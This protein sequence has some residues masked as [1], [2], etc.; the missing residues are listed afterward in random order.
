MEE[1]FWIIV[2]IPDDVS[3]GGLFED[4]EFLGIGVAG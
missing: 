4:V 3:V 1:C 2:D